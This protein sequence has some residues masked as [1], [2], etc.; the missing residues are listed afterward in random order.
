MDDNGINFETL[1]QGVNQGGNRPQ[2]GGQSTFDRY[3]SIVQ[4]NEEIPLPAR[5]AGIA[6]P[7]VPSPGALA[8]LREGR[9]DPENRSAAEFANMSW[10]EYLPI[11]GSN[12]VPSGIEAIKGF[13]TAVMN[14][15]D[16]ATAIGK[17]GYG[18]GAKGIDAAGN[19]VGYGPVFDPATK[20][21]REAVADALLGSYKGRYGFGEEEGEFWKNLAVDPMGY[22]ADI[23]TIAS[24]GAGMAAKAGMINKA[25][26]VS[27]YAGYAENL[28]PVQLAMNVTG[29]TAST[30]GKAV[31]YLVMLSQKLGTGL[32][33]EVLQTARRAGLS[34]DREGAAA[35][36]SALKK[37]PNFNADTA[38]L[39]K[40]ALDE[41]QQEGLSN[42]K[43]GL[44]YSSMND[45]EVDMTLSRMTRDEIE[46]MVN[47]N[48]NQS[49]LSLE[50][51]Y[52][53]EDVNIANRALASIDEAI[54]HPDPS[55][56]T[57][58]E[59]DRL[60]KHIYTLSDQ[61]KNPVL[62]QRVSSMGSDLSFEMSMTDPAYGRA[63]GAYQ[64]MRDALDQTTKDFG[65][66]NM[67]DAQRAKK[68]ATVFKGKDAAEVFRRIEG[69]KSG[70]N[71]RYSLAGQAASP[72]MSER[73]ANIIGSMGGLGAAGFYL[74]QHPGAV[75]AAGLGLANA[76]PRL[77]AGTQYNLGRLERNINSAA[78]AAAKKYVPPVLTNIGSQLGEAMAPD[79]ETNAQA[80]GGR[81]ERNSGGRVGMPHE[82][83]AD[84]LVMAAERAKKGIS[85]GTESLL[86]M[87]DNHI[88]HA[89][90]VANRSI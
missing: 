77:A 58:E 75:L 44:R 84:Q 86:D 2:G 65:N 57:I 43:N 81:V 72:W 9:V 46:Q 54:T 32:P 55:G 71:L 30:A 14:P 78:A 48:A 29:K 10:G 25:G 27:K 28:D 45:A 50:P 4:G 90:E 15:I 59:L 66:P 34:G 17:L 41:L 64:A 47:K 20:G 21:E 26:N 63:M 38:G 83:A 88:A 5:G 6:T 73:G 31:P 23:A 69:T 35:F 74:G 18:L 62:K 19:A 39:F 16:T 60:K 70:K 37:N 36:V 7:P 22:G 42:Y 56:R 76:S 67:S 24:G 85:K 13:G 52:S 49:V 89:L 33:F 68:L 40:Q 3:N 87:S 8:R 11:V 51:P 80:Y 12:I 79:Y 53:P 82:A 1:G 61:I